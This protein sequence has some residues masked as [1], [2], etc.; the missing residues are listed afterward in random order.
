MLFTFTKQPIFSHNLTKIIFACSDIIQKQ[1]ENDE[2]GEK[3]C[4][5]LF[6]IETKIFCNV[7]LK[8]FR[9]GKF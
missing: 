1:T 6:Q 5:S 4:E 7:S 3:L 2:K 9:L 8:T